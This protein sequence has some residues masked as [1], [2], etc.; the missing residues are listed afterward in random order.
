M[1]GKKTSIFVLSLALLLMIASTVLA[2]TLTVGGSSSITPGYITMSGKST[3]TANKVCKD[4]RSNNYLYRDD[5]L[6]GKNSSMGQNISTISTTC[7]G[8]NYPGIQTWDLSGSHM[9]YT[10]ADGF[11]TASSY[12]TTD[13]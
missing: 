1:K 5:V 8:T 3:T 13:W 2:V 11:S 7:T 6:A 10:D 12:A 9:G 4:I